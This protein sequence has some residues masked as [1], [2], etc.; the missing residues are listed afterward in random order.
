MVKD[1][2]G[3]FSYILL[4]GEYK[5]AAF[6]V[7]ESI[8]GKSGFDKCELLR[9]RLVKCNLPEVPINGITENRKRFDL[10]K[11][12]ILGHSAIL[13]K[14]INKR[15]AGKRLGNYLKTYKPPSIEIRAR[16]ERGDI[17]EVKIAS[18]YPF[19]AIARRVEH[20]NIIVKYRRERRPSILHNDIVML[21]C[22]E[23]MPHNDMMTCIDLT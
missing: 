8:Y 5:F 6:I 7:D 21:N 18:R 16:L 22:N 3:L 20:A 11:Y 13:E 9:E 10:D 14:P 17:A 12:A 23:E 15:K 4:M 2:E 1:N 19:M